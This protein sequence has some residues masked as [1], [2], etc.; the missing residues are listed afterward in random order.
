MVQAVE[1]AALR[2]IARCS[3]LEDSPALA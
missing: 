3:L 1:L 2:H